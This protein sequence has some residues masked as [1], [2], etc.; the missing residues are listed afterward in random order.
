[1]SNEPVSGMRKHATAVTVCLIALVIAGIGGFA[2]WHRSQGAFPSA[3]PAMPS[4]VAQRQD[5]AL[6][7]V[8]DS[9]LQLRSLLEGLSPMKSF[10][11][12]LATSDLLSRWVAVTDEIAA[13]VS[14]RAEVPFLLPARRVQCGQAAGPD[15]AASPVTW[16][17]RSSGPTVNPWRMIERTTTP[18]VM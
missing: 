2:L 9:D 18:K 4:P 15:S 6:P 17:N 12:W 14:P 7:S 3:P 11:G 16:I 5:A 10:H 13:D 8:A 1:M